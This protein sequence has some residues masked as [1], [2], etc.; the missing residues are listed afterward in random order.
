M[1]PPLTYAAV[2][3]VRLGGGGAGAV[4][5]GARPAAAAA[6]R[7]AALGLIE[8]PK[9]KPALLVVPADGLTL[10]QAGD[11]VSQMQAAYPDYTAEFVAGRRLAAGRGR[12]RAHGGRGP[13]TTG[14]WSRRG[15]WCWTSCG[16]R[17]PATPAAPDAET[18]ARWRPVREWLNDPKELA[19]WR[20]LA[21]PLARLADAPAADP[22]DAMAT[23]LDEKSFIIDLESIAVRR[24]QTSWK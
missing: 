24:S 11:R 10:T 9:G 12:R 20:T 22:V 3:G 4:G 16:R 19:G 6:R 14:C 15:R 2:R 17:R 8:G 23:F 1:T 5:G 7:G 13:T 18:P 21:G